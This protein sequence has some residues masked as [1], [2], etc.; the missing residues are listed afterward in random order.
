MEN[1][2]Y[3]KN[4]R[5]SKVPDNVT[6]CQICDR[7]I[8]WVHILATGDYIL[9][10]KDYFY[11]TVMGNIKNMTIEEYRNSFEFNEMY[12]KMKGIIPTDDTFI[13]KN[14]MIPWG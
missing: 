13:C 11:K 4:F 8:N 9:C 1:W 10:C 14:C 12:N 7:L 5:H 2:D 6:S 3:D